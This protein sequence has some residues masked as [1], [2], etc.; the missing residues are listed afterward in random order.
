MKY[1]Q[2][3]SQTVGPFFAYGL[4]PKQYQYDFKE[5]YN[6]ILVA[7]N[8]E[9]GLITIKGQVFD[10]NGT[11]IPDA[12]IEFWQEDIKAFGRFGTGT[13]PQNRFIFQTVKPVSEDGQAPFITVVVFMRGLLVHAFT[14]LYFSDEM[15]KN[16]QD[17]VLNLVPKNR[18]NTLI[19]HKLERNGREEYTFNIVMQ[20]NNETVFFDL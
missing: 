9:G 2:T 18:R 12:L 10:G 13:D 1:L 16:E 3:P 20:G 6:G 8:A 4:T 5:W 17:E 15:G 11:P 14:R 19:A 7:E